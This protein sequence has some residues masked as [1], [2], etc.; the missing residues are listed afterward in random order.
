VAEHTFLGLPA[1]TAGD[2]AVL[3][4][5]YGVP[6]PDPGLTAGCADAPAAIRARSGRLARFIGSHD[7]DLDGPMLPAGSAFR[8]VD[9]GDVPG[10][11]DDGSGN[12]TRAEAAVR[13]LLEAGAV[14]VLLG[15]DDSIP[16][17]TLRAYASGPIHVLQVDA[18]LDFRHEV[19]GVR[20]GYSSP[21]RRASELAH[22]GGITQ[23]GL[24]G[25]GSASPADVADA[26]AAGNV[27][28]TASEVRRQ[29]A[30]WVVDQL[31]AGAPLF[32]AFDVDGLDPAVAPAVS[33]MSP[34]GLTYDEAAEL[35]TGAA[36]QCRVVGAAFTEF[37]P[38]LD[39]ND[40]TALVIVRLVMQ[41]I[42]TLA[43]A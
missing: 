25:I 39:V 13:A 23:V 20:E 31:P 28:I 26:R 24:R 11:A 14:P 19:D 30:A 12:A 40:L 34:G 3:G 35:V 38:A 1:G 27:L 15:G 33:G 22:V 8:V 29:G 9:A 32:I 21:M 4:I 18:H 5:P 41:L 6:Y 37:V 16:I 7:F 43:R 17:P 36:R 10:S 2:V 42:G